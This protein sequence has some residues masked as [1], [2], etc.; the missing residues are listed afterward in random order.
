M[1]PPD[2]ARLVV[3]IAAAVKARVEAAAMVIVP[4]PDVPDAV[5]VA[6]LFKFKFAPGPT[7]RRLPLA[8]DP[9]ALRFSVPLSTPRPPVKVLAPVK[10]NVATPDLVTP[11]V[12]EMTEATARSPT[13]RK[14][15][16][17]GPKARVPPV[18][19]PDPPAF[20]ATIPDV[21]VRV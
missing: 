13:V 14:A 19:V 18:I 9:P 16:V 7:V 1:I 20:W 2:P 8:I 10:V 6:A 11:P 15:P 3:A 5:V 21:S 12:P 4:V 17:A